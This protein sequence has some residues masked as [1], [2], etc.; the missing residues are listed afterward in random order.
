MSTT[1]S[2]IITTYNWPKALLKTLKSVA[3]QTRVPDE[4]IIADDGSGK[5]TLAVITSFQ[6]QHPELQVIHSWQEDAG[7]RLSRSRNLAMAKANCDY[8]I[9]VDGDMILDKHFVAD[10]LDVAREG[11]FVAGRRVRLTESYSQQLLYTDEYPSLFKGGFEKHRLDALRCKFLSRV[12]STV[13]SETGGIHGCNM[14]FFRADALAVNGFNESFVGWGA[15]DKEFAARLFNIGCIKLKL[16]N[17]AIGYHVFHKELSRELEPINRQIFD[18]TLAN[19]LK[20][21]KTGV[22]QFVQSI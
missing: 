12:R 14:A 7:Y 5:E 8:I 20:R 9:F 21:C 1:V 4:I 22:S 11:Q 19:N 15:E 16:K 17:W 2:L 18:F 13:S 10:H 3:F 6:Y